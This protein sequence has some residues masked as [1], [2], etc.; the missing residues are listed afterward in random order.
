[1]MF[2]DFLNGRMIFQRKYIILEIYK[3][4]KFIVRNSLPKIHK[5]IKVIQGYIIDFF[6][7][8]IKYIILEIYKSIKFIVRNS[9]SK[10]HK[11][12]DFRRL[13]FNKVYKYLDIRR[14][15]FYRIDKKIRFANYKYLPIYFIAFIIFIG[16]VYLV[17]PTF[18]SYDK[19]K[20]ETI[21]CKDKNIK[22][23]IRGEVNY[24][25]YPTPRIKIK[26]LI[27]NDLI[28]KKNNLVTAKDVAI[29]L[30]LKN[31]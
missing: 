21:I 9:F 26:D 13:D 28:T 1:M 20:I 31:L 5:S 18:Y 3:S 27:I 15:D 12:T 29:K 7:F 22:C 23:L 17:I 25:F 16:F 14:Y 2:L 11:L 8:I 24:S 10:I 19:T 4:I 6:E 30:S